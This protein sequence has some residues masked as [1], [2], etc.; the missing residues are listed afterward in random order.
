MT[1]ACRIE[2]LPEPMEATL[3]DIESGPL[4]VF[5]ALGIVNPFGPTLNFV[6]AVGKST[7]GAVLPLVNVML[8]PFSQTVAPVG[9]FTV[10]DRWSLEADFESLIHLGFGSCPTLLLLNASVPEQSREP[11]SHQ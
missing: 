6:G 1:S 11:L 9:W 7:A 3:E 2:M 10:G 8:N 4:D 5:F